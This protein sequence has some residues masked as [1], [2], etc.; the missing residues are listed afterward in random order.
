VLSTWL[1]GKHIGGSDDVVAS[2]SSGLFSGALAGE[3]KERPKMTGLKECGPANFWPCQF[4]ALLCYE[5]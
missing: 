5:A 1:N 2:V 4:F 3:A